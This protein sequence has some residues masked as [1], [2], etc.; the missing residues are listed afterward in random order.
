MLNLKVFNKYINLCYYD[1]LIRWLN[2]FLTS[3][4]S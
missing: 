1:Q 3:I 4:L 2:F